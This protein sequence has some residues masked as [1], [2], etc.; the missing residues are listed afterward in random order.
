MCSE[1]TAWNTVEVLPAQREVRNLLK[2]SLILVLNPQ[3]HF[4]R[5]FGLKLVEFV[6]ICFLS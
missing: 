1:G 3:Q 5:K 4:K 6:K 2:G